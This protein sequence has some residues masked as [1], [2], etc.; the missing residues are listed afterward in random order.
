MFEFNISMQFYT[1]TIYKAKN[2][3]IVIKS[4][5]T[6]MTNRYFFTPGPLTV[7]LSIDSFIVFKKLKKK[8]FIKRVFFSLIYF[9]TTKL[10]QLFEVYEFFTTHVF[11]N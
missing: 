4:F 10:S 7:F 2:Y 9:F 3:R 1:L 11:T 6:S 5:F 8:N